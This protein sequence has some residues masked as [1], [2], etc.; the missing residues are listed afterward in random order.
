MDLYNNIDYFATQHKNEE[1]KEIR[2]K[3]TGI[4]IAL[5][6]DFSVMFFWSV[7]IMIIA[8]VM[9][10]SMTEVSEAL[11][12]P[13]IVMLLQAIL[14]FF[15]TFLPFF[16]LALCQRIKLSEDISFGKPKMNLVG[17]FVLLSVGCS[18]VFSII[19]NL[20]LAPLQGLG[21]EIPNVDFDYPTG[22]CGVVMSFLAIAVIPALLEEFAIRGVVLKML[23]PYGDGFAIFMSALVFGVMHASIFQIPYAFMFGV[24]LAFAVIKTESIWTGVLLHFVN[25]AISI[26]LSYAE[27]YLSESMAGVVNMLFSFVTINLLGLGILLLIKADRKVLRLAPSLTLSSGSQKAG[28]FIFAPMII[29]CFVVAVLFGFVLR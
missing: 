12:D 9:G 3:A 10:F 6:A 7:P 4:G 16:V 20:L 26:T 22:F 5:L 25:N 29:I 11:D 18:T 1:K 14:A 21:I 27:M 28:Y 15:M 2:R 17:P 24:V 19:T 8:L 23:R 13:F